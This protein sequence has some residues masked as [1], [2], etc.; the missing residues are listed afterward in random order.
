LDKPL[1]NN[2]IVKLIDIAEEVK[3]RD[4][5]FAAHFAHGEGASQRLYPHEKGRQAIKL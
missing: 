3:I 1:T 5:R 2:A 4:L